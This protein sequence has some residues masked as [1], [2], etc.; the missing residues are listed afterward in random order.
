MRSLN[1][2]VN[3]VIRDRRALDAIAEAL[4]VAV[5]RN[6]EPSFDAIARALRSTGR[7]VGRHDRVKRA[8]PE[9]IAT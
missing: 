4:E 5:E 6:M 7:R 2:I 9:R 3:A 8:A 1:Q